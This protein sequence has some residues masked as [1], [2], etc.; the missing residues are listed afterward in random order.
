[1]GIPKVY[2]AGP[3]VFLPDAVALGQKK[4]DIC[5][6]YGLE[7]LFP[8]DANLVLAG[9][10]PRAAG[11]LIYEANIGLIEQAD[12]CLANLTPYRGVS[13]DVG[14]A[15][16]VGHMRGLGKPIFAYS[17]TTALFAERVRSSLT[18][19]AQATHDAAGL[20]IEDF[21]MVDNL[22]LD[23]AAEASGR[24][25]LCQDTDLAALGP[26]ECAVQAAARVL[27]S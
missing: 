9:V 26:F 3:D 18:I 24:A 2:L 20:L 11:L 13:A 17:G 6:A 19:S 8:L 25:I 15:Y 10:E 23:G 7:G 21:G 1:M 16:E 22:M 14:T 4:R 27:L 12:A 5:A